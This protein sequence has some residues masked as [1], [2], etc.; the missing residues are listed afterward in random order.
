MTLWFY[1]HFASQTRRWTWQVLSSFLWE[2]E[3]ATDHPVLCGGFTTG[4]G[5]VKTASMRLR[6]TGLAAASH[7]YP[8]TTDTYWPLASSVTQTTHHSLVLRVARS[9]IRTLSYIF[10]TSSRDKWTYPGTRA[11]CTYFMKSIEIFFFEGLELINW[12]VMCLNHKW[13]LKLCQS[14]EK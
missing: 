5:R 6:V 14:E 9:I 7:L 10:M 4:R 8:L 3:T 1:Q 12:S 13:W 2:K 11:C